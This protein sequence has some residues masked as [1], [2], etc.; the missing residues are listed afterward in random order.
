MDALVARA[1][2]SLTDLAARTGDLTKAVEI[3]TLA[4]ARLTTELS[5]D[6]PPTSETHNAKSVLHRDVHRVIH[7][8]TSLPTSGD[9]RRLS[10]EAVAECRRR[11][12]DGVSV[13]R[14][15][16]EYGVGDSTMRAAV[17]GQTYRYVTEPPVRP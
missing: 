1:I 9:R 2:G 3:N 13:Y 12:R 17:R 16:R 5:T 14:L 15:A 6:T 10:A 4:V 11:A 8:P 7:R